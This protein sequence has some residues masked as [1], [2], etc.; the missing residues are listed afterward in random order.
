MIKHMIK[1]QIIA[2][3][4]CTEECLEMLSALSDKTRQKIIALFYTNKELC[5]ND[6]AQNFNLSRPTIS[7]HLNLMRRTKLLN[8]RKEGKEVYYSFNR[9]Y[10]IQM[11]ESILEDLKKCCC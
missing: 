9:D 2:D 5:V 4:C 11:M 10:V 8:S 1:T 7:H 3:T 6:I